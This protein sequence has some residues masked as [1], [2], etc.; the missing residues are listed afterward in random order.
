MNMAPCGCVSRKARVGFDVTPCAMHA[1]APIL[2]DAC[3]FI[4]SQLQSN[5]E[6]DDGC[7]YYNKKSA[8]ELQDPI[9]RLQRAIAQAEGK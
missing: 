6:W 3:K 1:A 7:F 2:L 5:G 8:S 9:E 4:L